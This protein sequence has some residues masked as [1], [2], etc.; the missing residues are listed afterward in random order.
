MEANIGLLKV[1]VEITDKYNPAI[2]DKY[3]AL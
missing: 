2:K 3:V 1:G